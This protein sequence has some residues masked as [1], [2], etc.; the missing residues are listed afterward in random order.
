ML[1]NIQY[2]QGPFIIQTQDID[3]LKKDVSE[4]YVND[5]IT[6]TKK[7][8]G[9][10]EVLVIEGSGFILGE[11]YDH[12]IKSTPLKVKVSSD[13]KVDV[14]DVIV[15]GDLETSITQIS[16][17]SQ[18][19]FKA[20][21]D[22]LQS[23]K[24]FFIENVDELKCRIPECSKANLTMKEYQ[25]GYRFYADSEY[26]IDII[27]KT[28]KDV[29]KKYDVDKI[30]IPKSKDYY[31]DIYGAGCK[32]AFNAFLFYPL[33]Y[34]NNQMIEVKKN[35]NIDQSKRLL[36]ILKSTLPIFL[37]AIHSDDIL[38]FEYVEQK[39]IIHITVKA[40]MADLLIAALN[41]AIGPIAKGEIE[42]TSDSKVTINKISPLVTFLNLN[43]PTSENDPK[44]NVLTDYDDFFGDIN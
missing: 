1:N 13:K 43:N 39:S 14:A 44:Q 35:L 25:I 9:K 7:I 17:L 2:Y 33:I 31:I 22:Y 21:E 3:T 6:S 26:F 18:R 20:M 24:A 28:F 36:D 11:F 8:I 34:D 19:A 23:K 41:L 12:F 10:D 29:F 30:V 15:W 4:L 40:G 16:I 32:T 27:Y 38:A 42:R 37:P 5:T